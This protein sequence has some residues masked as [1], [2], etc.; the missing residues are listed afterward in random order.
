MRHRWDN[1]RRYT[2]EKLATSKILSLTDG[3]SDQLAM[4]SSGT[5]GLPM[6][7]PVQKCLLV[8]YDPMGNQLCYQT[9]E[10]MGAGLT[11]SAPTIYTPA[12]I[13]KM[14]AMKSRY[15]YLA[16]IAQTCF[17][18]CLPQRT[19]LRFSHEVTLMKSH[20]YNAVCHNHA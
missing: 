12:L 16:F 4:G 5:A 7:M 20:N 10:L 15:A 11:S 6:G 13:G 9:C 17:G 19:H 8:Q 18:V 1:L 14:A 2:M 3:C